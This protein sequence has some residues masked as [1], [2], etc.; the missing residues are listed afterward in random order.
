MNYEVDLNEAILLSKVDFEKNKALYNQRKKAAEEE[1]KIPVAMGA[2]KTKKSN[3]PV[4]MSLDQFNNLNAR[5][6]A[7][8]PEEDEEECNG[9]D[10]E[11]D[12]AF[13][14]RIVGETKEAIEREENL[15]LRKARQPDVYKAITQ[16]QYEDALEKKDLQI[17]SL[18]VK[19]VKHKEELHSVKTR[20][21]RLCQILANGES[22][23]FVY[24]YTKVRYESPI[25]I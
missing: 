19:V 9:N 13:F 11:E 25:A 2:K 20:N 7:E 1:K 14:E 23:C 6:D 15:A 22:K 8:Q 5:G 21:K 3:K 12:P 24:I 16:A 18:N 17:A 10:V 4:P